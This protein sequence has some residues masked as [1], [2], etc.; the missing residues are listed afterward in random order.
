[1]TEHNVLSYL[2]STPLASARPYYYPGFF[3]ALFLVL[4]RIAIGWHFCNEGLEKLNSYGTNKPFSAEPYLR[5]STGPLT[6]YFRGL[7]PDVDS[8]NKLTPEALKAEW[9]EDTKRIADHFNFD[10]AQLEKLDEEVNKATTAADDWFRGTEN[11]EKVKKYFHDLKAIEDSE[12]NKDALSYE[13]ERV[14]VAR[15]TLETDRKALVGTIYGWTTNLREAVIKIA[16]KEQLEG[17]GAYTPV[18]TQLDMINIF[19]AYALTI[20]GGCL[21]LGFLTPVAA[22]GAAGYLAMF[23]FSMPPWPGLPE[24]PIAEGHY[25]I[26]NKNLVEMFACLALAATPSGLWVG[27]DAMLFGPYARRAA[28]RREQREAERSARRAATA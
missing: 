13:K 17:F 25:F 28:L 21:M 19:T 8:K 24:A 18:K 9:R 6:P 1:M 5:A 14:L 11:A 16:T 3:G 15:K 27:L 10:Q 7:V 26:V 23:Y 22:L 4:L 20:I 12:A 2:R